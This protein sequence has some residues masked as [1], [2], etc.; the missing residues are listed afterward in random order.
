MISKVMMMVPMMMSPETMGTPS[1]AGYVPQAQMP[2]APP[3][4][5]IVPQMSHMMAPQIS[6]NPN[7]LST[8]GNNST[9]TSSNS[10]SNNI[11]N[12]QVMQ[13]IMQQPVM[14]HYMMQSQHIQHPSVPLVPMM[15]QDQSQ[16]MSIPTSTSS[17]S[18]SSSDG[19]QHGQQH[20]QQQHGS[21]SSPKAGSGGNLAHNA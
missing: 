18:N 11:P 9:H 8:P 5:V 21:P 12:L 7:S 16:N 1:A 15:F 19:S 17:T 20:L 10:A 6:Q 14:Q 3:Q 4:M 13:Q 2:F